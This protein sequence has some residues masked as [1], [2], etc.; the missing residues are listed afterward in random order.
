MAFV[1]DRSHSVSLLINAAVIRA[2]TFPTPA[3][4]PRG[5]F[6]GARVS[7]GVDTVGTLW[8]SVHEE[9]RTPGWTGGLTQSRGTWSSR[10][11][12]VCH[13][14]TAELWTQ[15]PGWSSAPTTTRCAALG[16]SLNL[17][18]PQCSH[19]Q[20]AENAI[21]SVELTWSLQAVN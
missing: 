6:S 2:L 9:A 3:L 16:K 12:Q 15:S 18:E 21:C 20:N 19:L 13:R 1:R 5:G 4:R 7:A 10:G 11:E 8:L 17:S 14:D